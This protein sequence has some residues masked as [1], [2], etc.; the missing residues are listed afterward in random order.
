MF[1]MK[2]KK[3]YKIANKINKSNLSRKKIIELLGNFNPEFIGK[4]AYKRCFKVKC[5]RRILVF[6]VGRNIMNDI[7]H[8]QLSK[9][10]RKAKYSKI[11]WATEYCLLQKYCDNSSYTDKEFNDLKYVWKK[12][13]FVD[14]RRANVGKINGRLYA[15]DI[16]KSKR[17]LKSV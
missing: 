8:Y 6:K 14:I 13:G 15:F 11:Y 2:Y 17:W 1:K 5:N 12:K 10:N 3:L 7:S 4:G 9:G 16:I